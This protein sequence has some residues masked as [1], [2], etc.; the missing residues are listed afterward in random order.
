MAP[1]TPLPYLFPHILIISRSNT[2][3]SIARPLLRKDILAPINSLHIL[4]APHLPRS[5]VKWRRLRPL[6]HL[7]Q[8][9][10]LWQQPNRR[11]PLRNKQSKLPIPRRRVN[12]LQIQKPGRPRVEQPRHSDIAHR[13]GHVSTRQLIRTHMREVA[14]HGDLHARGAGALVNVDLVAGIIGAV[15]L[16]EAEDGVRAAEGFSE[17]LPAE[18]GVFGPERGVVV[19]VELVAVC[20]GGSGAGGA[21]GLQVGEN[22]L[23][24]D[25][26]G[27]VFG[28]VGHVEDEAEGL[29][30]CVGGEGALADRGGGG[31]GGEAE[32][33]CGEH[34]EGGWD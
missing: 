2:I 19:L 31:D 34:F 23:A 12:P 18:L 13:K 5:F 4:I 20:F 16:L 27:E 14:P 9:I 10:T 30:G 33:G 32:E 15:G 7:M 11:T 24:V 17:E 3:Q 26:G 6:R 8:G 1:I 25:A 22:L 28:G 21:G 29:G